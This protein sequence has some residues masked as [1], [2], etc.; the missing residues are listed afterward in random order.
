[1]V[2]LPLPQ[3]RCCSPL[4]RVPFLLLKSGSASSEVSGETATTTVIV[5]I[6]IVLP[7]SR[8]SPHPFP[9]SPRAALWPSIVRQERPRLIEPPTDKGGCTAATRKV[10]CYWRA[11]RT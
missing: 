8:S 3:R 10:A 7:P 9:P 5:I 1:M 4:P 6:F 11:E 2:L